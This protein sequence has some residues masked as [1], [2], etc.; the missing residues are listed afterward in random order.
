VPLVLDRAGR[1]LGKRHRSLSMRSV[2]DAGASPEQLVGWL[3]C[4]AGIVAGPDP[5][6]ARDLIGS[7]REDALTH[8]PTLLADDFL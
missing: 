2:L 4:S 6:R 7:F 1:R 3:A 8:V 5:V